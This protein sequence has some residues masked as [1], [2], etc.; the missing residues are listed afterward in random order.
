LYLI[1]YKKIG[2][3]D[4]APSNYSILKEKE[5]DPYPIIIFGLNK[6]ISSNKISQYLN[7]EF[8]HYLMIYKNVKSFGLP[9]KSWFDAPYWLL[10]LIDKF[11]DVNEE[12]E[13]YKKSKGYL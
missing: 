10:D 13:R 11:D 5:D 9:Y 3:D 4:E 7:F 12:Y 2:S 8:Y 6:P 1:G